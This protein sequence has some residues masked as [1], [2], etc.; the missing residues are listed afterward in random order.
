VVVDPQECCRVTIGRDPVVGYIKD[1]KVVVHDTRCKAIDAQVQERAFLVVW[2]MEEETCS[3]LT[4]SAE[5]RP[6]IIGSITTL[7]IEKNINIKKISSKEEKGL[8]H[9]S[10]LLDI[11]V[12]DGQVLEKIRNLPGVVKATSQ[13]VGSETA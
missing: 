1:N 4:I 11:P 10:L 3:L 6:D 13:S 9:L 12:L 8:P 5:D 2:D 7:L